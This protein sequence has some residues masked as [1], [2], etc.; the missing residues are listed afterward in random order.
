MRRQ[1][2]FDCF[3]YSD[4]HTLLSIYDYIADRIIVSAHQ[5]VRW[6]ETFRLVRH[7]RILVLCLGLGC[8]NPTLVLNLKYCTVF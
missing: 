8:N 7:D 5:V 1:E 6:S 2:T 4:V 3:S